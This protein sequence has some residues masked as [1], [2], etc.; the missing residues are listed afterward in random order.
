[1]GAAL[2]VPALYAQATNPADGVPNLWNPPPVKMHNTD[3]NSADPKLV[4]KI[5]E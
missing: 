3:T 1:M 2:A 5:P 4:C